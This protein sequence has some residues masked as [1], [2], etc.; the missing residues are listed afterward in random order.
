MSFASFSE[1]IEFNA[2]EY[3]GKV[4][5]I[6]Y[7][8]GKKITYG[9]FNKYINQCCNFFTVCSL[10]KG[11]IV[12]VCVRN[13]F[14]FIVIYFAC[15]RF[16]AAINPLPFSFSY[17]EIRK[18]LK[19][20]PI[21]ILFIDGRYRDEKFDVIGQV[22]FMNGNYDHFFEM[23]SKY[24]CDY[25][26]DVEEE[27]VACYYYSSGTTSNPKCIMYTHKNM[28]SLVK[29]MT[30]SFDFSF[31]TIHLGFLPLGH[32]AI[33][34]Y[35]LLPAIYNANT[36]VLCES[37]MKIRSH[38]WK[39]VNEYS[40]TYVEVVPTILFMMLNTP[41]QE[42]DISMNKTLKYIGCGSAPLALDIQKRFQDKFNIPVVNLYGLSETGPTHYDNPLRQGWQPGSIGKEISGCECIVLR[43]DKSRAG[44]GETGE[45][46]IRGNNVFV[47]YYNNDKAYR[48]AMHEEFFLTGDLGFKDSNGLFFF[49]DRKKDLIIKG[50]INIVPA[51][52]EEVL[53]QMD[54]VQIAVAVGIDDIVY[55]EDLIAF[56]KLKEGC[57]VG[58]NEI[59]LFC[60]QNLQ[61]IRRPKNVYIVDEIPIGPSGKVLR[62]EFRRRYEGGYYE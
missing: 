8:T 3:P 48:E 18:N 27:R 4:F 17:Q 33:T 1:I 31:E 40:S 37:F 11:D 10:K 42:S 36:L 45:L 51:E 61:D 60:S 29:S 14:A 22:F 23:L 41:Y 20:L 21:N 57:S 54:K 7:M 50:G 26:Y 38:F 52:I 16:N 53:Y 25:R 49:V 56:V 30:K 46:A 39:I 24:S 55:G 19:C 32:T 35:S 2:G 12:S 44:I 62:R 58:K 43:E 47:G 59:K 28:V 34:N 6:E 5:C 9:E 13:S 15:I